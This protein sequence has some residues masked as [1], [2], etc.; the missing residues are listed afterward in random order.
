MVQGEWAQVLGV[1]GDGGWMLRGGFITV[2]LEEAPQLSE[3][4]RDWRE[5][6]RL[7][8]LC[9]IQLHFMPIS[10]SFPQTQPTAG[11]MCSSARRY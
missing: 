7:Q 1:P 9:W 2:H 4:G 5:V 11:L 3:Q 6:L 10:V 8:G